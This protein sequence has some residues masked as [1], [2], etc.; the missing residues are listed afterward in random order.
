MKNNVIE[1]RIDLLESLKDYRHNYYQLKDLS[2]P[3]KKRYIIIK[4]IFKLEKD[5]IEADTIQLFYKEKYKQY[6]IIFETGYVRIDINNLHKISQKQF[7]DFVNEFKN[8]LDELINPK[9]Y[10]FNDI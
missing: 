3:N 5:I 2:D 6:A 9:I 4:D 8:N 10:N 1:E 7:Q